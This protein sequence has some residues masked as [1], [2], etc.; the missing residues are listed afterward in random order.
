ME[1]EQ[2]C[3]GVVQ[4]GFSGHISPG[5]KTRAANKLRELNAGLAFYYQFQISLTLLTFD[6]TGLT[7][8]TA[9]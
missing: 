3:G 9:H 4:G 6:V 2:L 1:N 8:F 7:L 5:Y